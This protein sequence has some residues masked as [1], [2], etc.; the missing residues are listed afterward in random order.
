MKSASF[1]LIAFILPI[2]AQPV[3]QSLY[4]NQYYRPYSNQYANQYSSP[5]LKSASSPAA[6][7]K[8]V[9]DR[10]YFPWFWIPSYANDDDRSGLS[11]AVLQD[12]STSSVPASEQKISLAGTQPKAFQS[13]QDGQSSLNFYNV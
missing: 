4:P 1:S 11:A 3:Q 9:D 8:N 12:Q 5:A 6:S 13:E 2:L 7:A 10:M